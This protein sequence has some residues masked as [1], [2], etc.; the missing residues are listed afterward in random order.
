[1]HKETTLIGEIGLTGEI[2]AVSHAQARIKEAAKMGFTR[3][4]VPTATMKQ[5][6][7]IKGMAIESVSFLRDAVEVLFEG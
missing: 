2:R 5:L 1:V 4:L 3:C 7:K 6:A